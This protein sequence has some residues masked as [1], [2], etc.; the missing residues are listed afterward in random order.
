MKKTR[1]SQTKGLKS[2]KRAARS[3]QET[4]IKKNNEMVNLVVA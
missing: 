1:L 3:R 4:C 2:L